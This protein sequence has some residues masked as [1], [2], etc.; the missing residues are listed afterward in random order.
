[1]K[2]VVVFVFGFIIAHIGIGL[3][4]SLLTLYPN[5]FSV[6]NTPK[7]L[8]SLTEVYLGD[9]NNIY[10]SS[11]VRPAIQVYN[12]EGNFLYGIDVPT[13]GSYDIVNIEEDLFIY[14]VREQSLYKYCDGKITQVEEKNVDILGDSF[15]FHDSNDK[16]RIS[17]HLF[18]RIKIKNL[19]TKEKYTI[20]LK[21]TPTRLTYTNSIMISFL[22][23]IIAVS[24]W[25]YPIIKEKID[26]GE[27]DLR[28]WH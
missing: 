21:N 16:Y 13:Y 14:L 25:V 9:D 6:Y 12:M 20:T 5:S 24:P 10:A 7:S 8:G 11:T 2:K 27:I 4:L 19:E 15:S 26:S 3:F 1:M 18:H 17:S 22:G 28:F 23:I